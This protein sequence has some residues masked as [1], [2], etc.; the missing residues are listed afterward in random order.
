MIMLLLAEYILLFFKIEGK[1]L[2]KKRNKRVVWFNLENNNINILNL[3]LRNYEY[4]MYVALY[5]IRML[6]F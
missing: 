3:Y 4:K 5:T 2:K 1:K 6:V